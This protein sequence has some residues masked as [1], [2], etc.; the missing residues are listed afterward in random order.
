M[1]KKQNGVAFGAL[2]FLK[3]LSKEKEVLTTV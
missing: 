3:S 1:K 2:D